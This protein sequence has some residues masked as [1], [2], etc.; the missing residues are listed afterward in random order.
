[1]ACETRY[2]SMRNDWLATNFKISTAC[3]R[4]IGDSG[5]KIKTTK[6]KFQDLEDFTHS[7]KLPANCNTGH[8]I[9]FLSIAV[10]YTCDGNG[11]VLPWPWTE[12]PESGGVAVKP[13]A[14]VHQSGMSY[15]L[16]QKASKLLLW[17]C[18]I[19]YNTSPC[20]CSCASFSSTPSL[21][22]SF[23]LVIMHLR[24]LTSMKAH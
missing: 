24:Y 6:I 14:L 1:M 5:H 21:V 23:S 4:G 17:L 7:T 11:D 22:V 19:S 13:A 15:L 9:I 10:G 18:C 12:G 2:Y 8:V 16:V 3:T 20:I